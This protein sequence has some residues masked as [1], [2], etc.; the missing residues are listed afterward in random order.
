MENQTCFKIAGRDCAVCLVAEGSKSCGHSAAPQSGR[1][2]S[3]ITD[4]LTLLLV[5]KIVSL[6]YGMQKIGQVNDNKCFQGSASPLTTLAPSHDE[7]V[8][9]KASCFSVCPS[10]LPYICIT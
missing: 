7:P 6:D 10:V 1:I 2:S 5:I 3:L 9:A 4:K 8:G